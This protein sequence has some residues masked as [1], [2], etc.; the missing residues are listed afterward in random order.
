VPELIAQLAEFQL[1]LSSLDPAEITREDLDQLADLLAGVEQELRA[2][3]RSPRTLSV[4]TTLGTLFS[5][6]RADLA[7]ALSG[8]LTARE[9][10]AR[11]VELA[12]RHVPGTQH[13]G[14][15]QLQPPNK[16]ETVA[17]TSMVADACDQAQHES[18]A[19]P[20]VQLSQ[21]H[22]TM[23]IDDLRAEPRWPAFAARALEAGV[24]SMLVCELPATR[25][26]RAALSLYSARRRGFTAAAELVAPAFASRA[27]IALAHASEVSNL[28][29]AI[30]SRQVI[31]EA[32]GILMERHRLTA[33]H[34]FERLVIASQHR[35]I[36]L[37]ELAGRVTETGEE[38][39]T[40]GM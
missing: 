38:P 6:A 32:V 37:R 20:T 26:T 35:H 1:R 11:V 31:G 13:A 10:L 17:A 9:Q 7:A 14:I 33:E 19:G 12:V 15:A 8:E 5:L 39:D 40:V 2:R 24:R 4:P 27:S 3:E 16:I 23:R 29:Q 18:G 36:K 28:H 30:A 22:Q 21:A 34:A 25:G